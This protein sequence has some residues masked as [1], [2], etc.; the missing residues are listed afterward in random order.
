MVIAKPIPPGSGEG[1]VPAN[2]LIL[3]DNSKSMS[4]NKIGGD[5]K[6]TIGAT[7]DGAGNKILASADTA[8]GGLYKFDSAGDP[9]NFG[10]VKRDGSPYS[11]ETWY[12]SD[13]RDKTCDYKLT[14]NGLTGSLRY[15][16]TEERLTFNIKLVLQ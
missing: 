10:G 13:A 12:P 2:I 9:I 15:Q 11:V 5:I 8:R 16:S 7:I 3:L 1:D 14:K 6:S 4:N